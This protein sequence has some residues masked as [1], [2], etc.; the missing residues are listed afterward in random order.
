MRSAGTG[1][2]KPRPSSW[3]WWLAVL[4]GLG[5]ARVFLNASAFPL[6]CNVDEPL[7]YDMVVKYASGRLPARPELISGEAA[8]VIAEYASWE[9]LNEPG[10]GVPKEELTP[11]WRLPPATRDRVVGA[12]FRH[13]T[14][15]VNGESLE[16][17]AYCVVAAGWLKAGEWLGWSGARGAF[18]I[19]W[20]GALVVAAVIGLAGMALRGP[21]AGRPMVLVGVP[22]LLATWPQDLF[23]SINDGVTM[24]LW[25]AAAFLLIAKSMDARRWIVPAS[26]GGACAGLAMLSSFAAAPAALALCGMPL[27]AGRPWKR[28]WRRAAVA[29]AFAA[30]PVAGWLV[31]NLAVAG[32]LTGMGDKAA[33]IGWTRLPLS[34]LFVHP[35]FTAPGIWV[36]L[37]TLSATFWRGEFAWH[38]VPMAWLA[39]EGGLLA[40]GAVALLGV[41][42]PARRPGPARAMELAGVAAAALSFVYLGLLSASF[43][44]GSKFFPSREFPFLANGR[45]LTAAAVPIFLSFV[46]GLDRAAGRLSSRA[47]LAGVG[48]LAAWFLAVDVLDWLS[49]APSVYNWFHLP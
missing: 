25:G 26:A 45:L 43:D 47:R 42:V 20:L 8:S 33:L 6:F 14:G 37:K 16:P 2:R 4:A 41:L 10:P 30:V 32:H 3:R 40:L 9:Y 18:W 29:A 24:A 27:L 38:G 15:V 23:A 31:R 13:W 12:R 11:P 22:L 19:R 7:H 5:G 49:A 28:M 44:F 39:L 35:V 46:A 21:F 34:A 48:A 1:S 36:F 17:P